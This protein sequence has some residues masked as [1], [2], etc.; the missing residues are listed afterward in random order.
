MFAHGTPLAE[1]RDISEAVEWSMPRRRRLDSARMS[2]RDGNEDDKGAVFV[3]FRPPRICFQSRGGLSPISETPRLLKRVQ[4]KPG[5]I[6][7]IFHSSN[8]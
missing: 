7:V 1:F 2:E 3:E 5:V 6:G 4:E 8:S